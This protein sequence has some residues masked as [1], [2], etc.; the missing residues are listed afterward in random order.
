MQPS[1]WGHINCCNTSYHNFIIIIIIIII[2][3]KANIIVT[4]YIKNVTGGLYTLCLF[5]ALESACAYDVGMLSPGI[6]SSY[7]GLDTL[8]NINKLYFSR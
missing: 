1:L 6:V 2:I 8:Q 4:L 7:R 3:M 5:I